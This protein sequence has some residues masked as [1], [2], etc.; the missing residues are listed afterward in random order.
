MWWGE[1]EERRGHIGRG[2]AG[3]PLAQSTDCPPGLALTLTTHWALI[4][5]TDCLLILDT[6][7]LIPCHILS[8]DPSH[9]PIRPWPHSHHR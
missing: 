9:G 8:P 3:G 1:G 4:L 6:G 7:S 5:F 2:Q